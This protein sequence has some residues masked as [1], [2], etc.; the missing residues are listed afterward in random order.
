MRPYLR[1][2]AWPVLPKGR[3]AAPRQ[4]VFE[5]Q[6]ERMLE[7]IALVVAEKG[8]AAAT[9]ADVIARAGVSRKTFYEQFANKEA[10]F[11]AAYDTGVRLLI[12]AVEA[13][14]EEAPDWLEAMRAG[15]SRY[16]ESLSANPAFARTFLVEILAAGP[17]ALERRAAVHRRF[18]EL[19]ANSHSAARETVALP[20][21]PRATHRAAVG[22]INELV[23]DHLVNRGA[24]SLP[25]LLGELLEI[26]LAL[27]TGASTAG[28]AGLPDA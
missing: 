3:N 4:F 6:R 5:S 16:L 9:V 20:A 17:T 18:A 11:L 22:A 12:S 24:D 13:A 26:Q 23:T 25:A 8:Y 15:T 14:I 21:V 2:R 1:E 28:V 7:A 27:Y 10:C 19:H